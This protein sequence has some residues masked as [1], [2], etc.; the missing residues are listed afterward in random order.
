MVW[1][2]EKFY[3]NTCLVCTRGQ[4]MRTGF[5]V[6]F[7]MKNLFLITLI[8]IN[9]WSFT[10][11]YAS[12]PRRGHEG[13][14]QEIIS[15]L[16][17]RWENKICMQIRIVTWLYMI[18]A[19]QCTFLRFSFALVRFRFLFAAFLLPITTLYNLVAIHFTQFLKHYA[20][21]QR[22]RLTIKLE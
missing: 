16:I 17:A 14:I 10:R 20:S 9:A 11:F 22:S 13:S 2:G 4:F 21:K 19:C 1:R 8:K 3:F 15:R 12:V 5:I 7:E 6:R 18:F